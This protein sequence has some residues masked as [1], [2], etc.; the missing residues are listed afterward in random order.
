MQAAQK[1]IIGKILGSTT[2]GTKYIKDLDYYLTK[3]HL[4]A[5]SDFV[6]GSQQRST[7]WY[8]NAAPQWASVNGGNWKMLENNIRE[9][10]TDWI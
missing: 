10:I 1:T 4:A 8:V 3:G 2:L 9:Y 7:F 5:R 6:Y